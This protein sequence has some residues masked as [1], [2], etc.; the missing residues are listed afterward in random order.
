MIRSPHLA[1]QVI[2]P[3]K[4]DLTAELAKSR[5]MVAQDDLKIAEDN[6]YVG[7]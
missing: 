3:E 2:L 7:Q 4:H 6:R 5:R 1:T